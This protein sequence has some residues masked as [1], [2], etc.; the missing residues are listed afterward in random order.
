MTHKS[1][2]ETTGFVKPLEFAYNG[3]RIVVRKNDG[4]PESLTWI[5]IAGKT[6]YLHGVLPGMTRREVKALALAWLK[7]RPQHLVSEQLS[8]A[9]I[10]DLRDNKRETGAYARNALRGSRTGLGSSDP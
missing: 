10:S 3:Q 7:E 1:E 6:F 8:A 2:R 9:E 5:E 4:H